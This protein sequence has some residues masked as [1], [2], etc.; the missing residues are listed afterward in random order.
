MR[1]VLRAASTEITDC[2]RLFTIGEEGRQRFRIQRHYR[3][4]VW[5]E[6]PGHW[7]PWPAACYQ[8]DQPK[9]WLVQIAPYA[10]LV[11]KALQIV[12]PVAA[13]VADMVLTPDQLKEAQQE[14][15]AMTTLV[16][17][18]PVEDVGDGDIFVDN[19]ATS[20]LTPAEGAAA[21]GLQQLLFAHDHSRRF[22]DLHRVPS[23]VRRLCLGM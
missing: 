3:L 23:P 8:I 2:P 15:S 6:H 21:R 13:S 18:L 11:F 9:G 22:G 14:I 10:T 12:V 17:G 20:Q 16:A 4:V 1:R 7:H 5:C 19:K